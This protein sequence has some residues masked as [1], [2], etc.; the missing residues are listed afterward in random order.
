MTKRLDQLKIDALNSINLVNA[1]L[2]NQF[3]QLMEFLYINPESASPLRGNS[4]PKFGT[5]EYLTKIANKFADGRTILKPINSGKTVDP[6]LKKLFAAYS[7]LPDSQVT[8][9]LSHHADLMLLENIV[10]KILEHYLATKLEPH[11]WV[12][13]SGEVVSKIDFIRREEGNKFQILQ[14]KN[15]DVTENSSSSSGRGSVPKWARLKGKSATS[16]WDNFPDENL[17]SLLSENEFLEHGILI[18]QSWE[19]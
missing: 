18:Q 15:K 14:V 3:V 13:C 10:G 8:I 7:Q 5:S 17:K 4:P 12:W 6:L 11:G 2:S 1:D 16:N 9:S 19:E